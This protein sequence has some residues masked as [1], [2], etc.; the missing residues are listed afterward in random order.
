MIC[1]GDLNTQ[2]DYS[3]YCIIVIVYGAHCVHSCR[4]LSSLVLGILHL[5]AAFNVSLELQG[6]NCSNQLTLICRHSDNGAAPLWIHN[7]TLESGQVLGAAFLGAVYTVLTRT[8]HTATISGVDNVRALDGYSIQ[9]TYEDL[10]NL[11]RN[12]AVKYSFYP[13]QSL[14]LI[15]ASSYTHPVMSIVTIV[16]VRT[17][18]VVVCCGLFNLHSLRL[19]QLNCIAVWM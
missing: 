10:G 7:G 16:Y 19:A 8:E 15:C 11:I 12:D 1:I 2:S 14:M 9:C 13:G 18:L 17:K 3:N 4:F 5:T 6:G